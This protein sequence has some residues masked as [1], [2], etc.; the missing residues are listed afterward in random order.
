M[1]VVP[2]SSSDL[3][4]NFFVL[5]PA[6]ESLSSAGFRCSMRD[7]AIGCGGGSESAPGFAGGVAGQVK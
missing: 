2:F 1:T 6:D 5:C 3:L 4:N 7:I